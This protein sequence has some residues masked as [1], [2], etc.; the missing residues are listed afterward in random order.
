MKTQDNNRTF[1]KST[2]ERIEESMRKEVPKEERGKRFEWRNKRLLQLHLHKQDQ[3]E[4][5]KGN[6]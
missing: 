6:K 5:E 2:V 3:E 4:K 1:S